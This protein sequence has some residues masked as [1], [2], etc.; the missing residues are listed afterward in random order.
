M[1]QDRSVVVAG[2]GAFGSLMAPATMEA[3]QE[4]AAILAKSDMVPE[5][6][7]GKPADILIAGAMGSRLGLDWF[8]SLSGIAVIKGRPCLWGD[9]LLAVCMS[10]PDWADMTEEHQGEPGKP[11]YAAVCTV[12]RK[13]RAPVVVAFSVDDAQKAGLWGKAGPWQ[14]YP[15]RMLSMRARA[16]ALRAAFADRLAGFSAREE[17]ED[18]PRAVESRDITSETTASEWTPPTLVVHAATVAEVQPVSE[19]VG[20]PVATPTVI[21]TVI[22]AATA[23]S[24][25]TTAETP[26]IP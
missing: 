23:A 16:Q 22:P 17:M 3:A 8:S 21:P 12:Q 5:C 24:G 13:G 18:E 11:G 9:A 14:A 2:S 6:Y 25:P 20:T 10:T 7:R 4:A 15:R 26:S 1:S 19:P